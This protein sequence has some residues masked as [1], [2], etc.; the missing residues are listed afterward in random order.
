VSETEESAKDAQSVPGPGTMLRMAREARGMSIPE[1]AT[2]LKMSPRQIEAMEG[3]DFSRLSGATYIRGFIRNYARLLRID[4]APVLATLAEHTPLPLAELNAPAD[5]GVTM[6]TSG[7][8]QGKGL[9]AATLLALAALAVALAL[10]FDVLDLAS[11][12]NRQADSAAPSQ[13]RIAQPQVAQ[14]LPQPVAA[15]PS[16]EVVEAAAATMPADPSAQAPQ[17]AGMRQLIFSFDGSSWVE[18]RD[19]AGR[20]LLSQMNAKG[21][22]R[23]VEGSPPFQL[24]VGNAS[25]VR[26]QYDDQAVDL[27]PH[28][29]VEVARLT[30]D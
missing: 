18:V 22:T 17:T 16:S 26:L 5:A 20:T 9:F 14:P 8:R 11:L 13:P 12:L 25:N 10:Y 28:T 27:R 15:V 24:V 1:V 3:E 29:R 23:L 4:A 30:L 2:A 21:T 7:K 6:P 19:A